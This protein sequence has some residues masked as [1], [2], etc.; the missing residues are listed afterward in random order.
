LKEGLQMTALNAT[1]GQLMNIAH[2]GASGYRPENTLSAFR[3][4]MEL[5]ITMLECDVRY[6]LDHEIV[7]IHDR[8]VDRTTDG[9]GLVAGISLSEL[10]KLDAGS[11]F[12]KEFSK[13]TI[14]TLAEVLDIL[15][16]GTQLV[17]EI[18]DGHHFPAIID[19]VTAMITG[20]A[21]AG[22]VSV[23]SFHWAVLKRVKEL[24]PVIK[25]AILAKY[26]PGG[27]PEVTTISCNQATPTYARVEELI[28]DA[29]KYGVTIICPP[30]AGITRV[31]VNQIHA[32]GF[33]VR[34]WGLKKTSHPDEMSRLIA[35]GVDGMTTN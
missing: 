7:V 33:P 20:R 13:E 23:S 32:A 4:A 12:D 11:W 35:S 5:G 21:L 8:T 16:Q 22:R 1:H 15:E 2:R 24:N 26:H 25:T 9:H 27:T 10:K 19:D 29:V 3:F 34:A 18:K 14:P 28:S 6:S 17:V 31:M 30:A